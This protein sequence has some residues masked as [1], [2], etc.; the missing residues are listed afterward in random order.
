M[1]G[2]FSSGSSATHQYKPGDK[3][4]TSGL[5]KVTHDRDHLAEH[6]VT[7]VTGEVFPSCRDCGAEVRFEL[8]RAA[9]RLTRHQSFRYG[10]RFVQMAVTNR[11][12]ALG[13]SP[14]IFSPA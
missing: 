9:H 13:I 4:K 7:C 12:S 8:V 14:L 11:P 5:Y 1:S 6:E 2:F 10:Q 3:V